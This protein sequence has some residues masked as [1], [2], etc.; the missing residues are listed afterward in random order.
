MSIL[1]L[2]PLFTL[3]ASSLS[4]FVDVTIYSDFASKSAGKP[5]I[6]LLEVWAKCSFCD[7]GAS[8]LEAECA[9]HTDVVCY[10]A[11]LKGDQPHTFDHS[12]DSTPYKARYAPYVAFIVNGKKV[13]EINE[14]N[15]NSY[16]QELATGFKKMGEK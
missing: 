12:Y 9:K 10:K 11:Y 3:I 7:E 16:E 14:Y 8:I 1:Y 4:G 15:L 2:L 6:V 13:F 5:K